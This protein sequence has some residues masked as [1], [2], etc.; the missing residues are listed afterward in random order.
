MLFNLF[1]RISFFTLNFFILNTITDPFKDYPVYNGSD[2]G[3]TIKN[4]E[5]LFKVWAP[6][7]KEVKL[8]IYNAGNGGLETETYNLSKE[9]EGTW[10]YIS[11][12]VLLNKYYT[13]QILQDG[14]WSLETP[15]PYA[16][17]VGLNGKRGMIV[18]LVE[19][20]PT[21]W[22]HDKRPELKNYN[23][24]ILYEL[25]IR[26][27][28]ISANSGVTQKGK[29]IGLGETGT[30]SLLGEATGLDHI[31]ELGV[32]HVH[33][34]P[35][36]DFNSVDESRPEDKKYNWGYDPQN[37]NVPEGSY[38]TNPKDGRTRIKEFKQLIQQL[39]SNGLRVILDV[40]YNHT[41]DIIHS[42]FNQF[43]P[44]YYY[45]QNEKGAFSD[46]TGCG[47]ET[48]S[49][50]PMMRNFMIESVAYWA[51]EYHIDGFR[52]DLMGVHDIETMNLISDRLK[53]IDPTIFV[54]GEGWTS[55][56][57]PIPE[58]ERAVK[59]NTYKLNNIAAFNDDL[60]DAIKGSFSDVKTKGFASGTPGFAESIK[61][62]IVAGT[63]HQG[64]D[65]GKVD[66]SKAPW[67][68][69]PFQTINYVSCHDDN[70]LF[71]KLKISNPTASEA[72]LIKMDELSN[73]IILTSQGIPFLHAGVEML[74]TKNGIG[75]SYKS[76]D[77]INQI[78]WSRKTK[79]KEV[80]N[81]YK[82]LVSLRKQHPA[83][84]MSTTKKIQEHLTFLP[85]TDALMV[86]YSISGNANGDSWN[87]ILVFFNGSADVKKVTIPEGN[88]GVAV[89]GNIVNEKGIREIHGGDFNMQGTSSLIL[90]RK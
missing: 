76:P 18:N 14:K 79:Y 54:Y 19:T 40:V 43:A 42:S 85:I 82:A 60:R 6:K 47:N 13:F 21:G 8:R 45:R 61:F 4:H 35:S 37:Y 34:L 16:K 63:S 53:S 75:N 62:G 22:S 15:D 31:K 77:S 44:G 87:D 56:A 81:Y 58:N 7:A 49:E 30:K 67:A 27:A 55:G 32:T 84:R 20:D 78:D 5:T 90:Y 80:F 70:T 51:K 33:L 66:Y 65:Y 1:L 3:V 89:E 68:R 57:S 46:A 71:D 26:D 24:I 23:D 28:T 25:H 9:K 73:T 59:A 64:L 83:F 48:A 10:I 29:F 39:H 11:K 36:F 72:E 38:S 50:R 74:R 88:W 86:S 12:S 2:L 69:E 41:S 17:A 52:F